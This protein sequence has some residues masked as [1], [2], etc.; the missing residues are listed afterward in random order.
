MDDKPQG[1]IYTP[2]QEEIITKNKHSLA[3]DMTHDELN[4]LR[5]RDLSIPYVSRS[6]IRMIVNTYLQ[7]KENDQ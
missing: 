4:R 3:I 5:Q 7:A 1:D 6:H 2:T